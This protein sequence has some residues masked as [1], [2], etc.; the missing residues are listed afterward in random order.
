MASGRQAEMPS[1]HRAGVMQG[2]ADFD[3]VQV[4]TLTAPTSSETR[5]TP[6]RSM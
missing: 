3:F 6:W 1:L 5:A 4:S 2:A